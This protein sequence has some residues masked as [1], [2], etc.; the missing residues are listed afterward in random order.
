MK[1]FSATCIS[2]RKQVA[3]DEI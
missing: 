2:W 3:F 1:I